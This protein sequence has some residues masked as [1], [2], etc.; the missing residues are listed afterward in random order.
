ME[1]R[2]KIRFVYRAVVI[3]IIL[4]VSYGIAPSN[5]ADI[6]KEKVEVGHDYSVAYKTKVNGE[7]D[8]DRVKISDPE[9]IEYL[10][11]NLEETEVSF[12]K[13][14]RPPELTD[15]EVWYE[16]TDM[17]HLKS[18]HITDSGEVHTMPFHIP[19]LRVVY[20]IS[21]E[22]LEVLFTRIEQIRD[23]YGEEY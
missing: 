12:K 14:T 1:T 19:Q 2:K 17:Q 6:M 4:M 9:G 21:D 18:M 5:L 11:R 8:I 16:I 15:G 23:K 3:V 22:D 7:Y 13:I 10:W 20:S